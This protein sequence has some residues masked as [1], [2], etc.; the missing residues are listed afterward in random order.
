MNKILK[1]SKILGSKIWKRLPSLF[2]SKKDKAPTF[3]IMFA[4]VFFVFVAVWRLNGVFITEQKYNA[5]VP[6]SDDYIHIDV[7]LLSNSIKTH[8]LSG[9]EV[10][11]GSPYHIVIYAMPD[12]DEEQAEFDQK[13][14]D[15][16]V[17]QEPYKKIKQAIIKNTKL[18]TQK[19]ELILELGDI[20]LM[21]GSEIGLSGEAH[22]LDIT[23]LSKFSED[24][25]EGP[26]F[27]QGRIDLGVQELDYMPYLMEGDLEMETTNG[28][29][30]RHFVV[31]LVPL[32]EKKGVNGIVQ[33]EMQLPFVFGFLPMLIL[34]HIFIALIMKLITR[35][36]YKVAVKIQLFLF[37]FLV[38]YVELIAVW[39]PGQ[40]WNTVLGILLSVIL[41]VILYRKYSGK[42]YLRI[43]AGTIT[44]PILFFYSFN[45]LLESI[46]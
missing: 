43:I 38:M 18:V 13:D 39:L 36:R 28:L 17:A 10:F 11:R 1:L 44:A 29:I 30:E 32:G 12:V 33:V 22:P 8:G 19:D 35:I 41:Q 7:D 24:G 31:G 3:L 37:F 27:V 46:F 15:A 26:K 20:D 4:L 14:M 23:F 2:W 5:T 42:G 40:R 16:F 34:M 21:G 45:F 9:T 25:I 6:Y